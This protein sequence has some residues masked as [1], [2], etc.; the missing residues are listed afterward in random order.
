MQFPVSPILLV[1][2]LAG[3]LALIAP[4][5]AFRLRPPGPS[6]TG[7]T[8]AVLPALLMLAL[9]Y[10][11]ALHMR[12][13]LGDW[14]ASIGER[15]FPPPLV[16]HARAATTSFAILFLASIFAWP[17]AF[18]LCLLVRRWRA[19]LYYLAVYALACLGSFGAMLLAPSRFLNWWRD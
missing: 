11:L 16:T 5:I 8:I 2:M 6:R 9:F 14:P 17:V 18:F 13:S 3:V 15:G 7:V 4:V 10:S 12:L 1:A 19:S